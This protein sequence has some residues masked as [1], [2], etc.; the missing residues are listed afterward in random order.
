MLK[1][2]TRNCRA[3][4]CPN[5]RS[6]LSDQVDLP[7][8]GSAQVVARQ[9]A[10]RARLRR[11]ERRWIQP[12]DAVLEIRV[13]A[14]D[15]VRTLRAATVAAG[16]VGHRD[17][18]HRGVVRPRDDHVDRHA[19]A[20]V[21][22]AADAPAAGPEAPRRDLVGQRAVERVRDVLR[23]GAV[24]RLVVER[25]L[26]RRRPRSTPASCPCSART[27]YCM[28]PREARAEPARGARPGARCSWR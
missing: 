3:C 18:A 4:V 12:A 11:R 26:R 25:V 2:S 5:R 19:A 21:D 17:A 13:H 22:D 20:G 7:E 28:P 15:E 23:V 9:V 6:L 24:L 8:L 14:R 1:I 16:D 27:W 10:E